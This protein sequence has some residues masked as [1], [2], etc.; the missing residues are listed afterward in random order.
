[1]SDA[2][3]SQTGHSGKHGF[4]KDVQVEVVNKYGVKT[5]LS[6]LVQILVAI[7]PKNY[8]DSNRKTLRQVLAPVI[9]WFQLTLQP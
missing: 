8:I 6:Q 7:F 2:R 5:C 3:R 9:W 4:V 1:M